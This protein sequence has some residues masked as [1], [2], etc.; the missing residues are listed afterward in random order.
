MNTRSER[1][2][3]LFD[4]LVDLDAAQRANRL[5]AIAADDVALADELTRMLA[6]DDRGGVLDGGVAAL[7]VTVA[8]ELERGPR[9]RNEAAGRRVGPF[10]LVRLLGR[11]GMGEVWLAS[12]EEGGFRQEVALKRLRHGVR[13]EDL[14][15][16]FVQERR[17]LAGLSHPGIARF[18]DGGVD[19][20]GAPWYAMELVDGVPLT[21]HARARD[22]D[23][24]AR[25]AL[26]AAVAE[27]VAYAQNRL[28]VHRDLK[29]SNILVDA[30]GRVRLLDFGIAKLLDEVPD[31]RATAS[32]VRAMSPAYAAPEQILG[33]PI[34]AATDVYALGVVLYELLTGGLPHARGDASLETLAEQ[35]RGE[36][37]E[38]PSRRL[39]RADAS[40]V[41]ALGGDAATALRF[42]RAAAGELDTIV[43][44]ALRREQERRYANAAAL[45]DDLRR[46]L[47]GRP[48]A[49]QP[50]TATYRLR[51]FVARHR[52]AVGSASAV[53]LALVAGTGIALWQAGV[54][55]D[56]ARRAG[57]E[58][59]RAEREAEKSDRV[60]EFM[61]S[62]LKAS[63][64]MARGTTEVPTVGEVVARAAR[65]VERDL[66]DAPMAQAAVLAEL[67]SIAFNGE[68][69][70]IGTAYA[71]RAAALLEGRPGI[72]PPL[73]ASVARVRGEA[74]LRGGDPVGAEAVF[75][76][77]SRLL[78][79]EL[80][81]P[82]PR[83]TARIAAGQ[84]ANG[85]GVALYVQ[86]RHADA[87]AALSRAA[88]LHAEVYGDDSPQVGVQHANLAM[89]H[90]SIGR[91]QEAL[92]SIERALAVHLLHLAPDDPRLAVLRGTEARILDDLGRSDEALRAAGEALGIAE[93]AHGPDAAELTD[94]LETLA[95]VH[96]MRGGLAEAEP[97]LA[98][99][100]AI[101][102]ASGDARRRF[103]LTRARG[104]LEMYR[105]APAAAIPWYA[106]ALEA[107]Q[108]HAAGEGAVPLMTRSMLAWARGLA[109][110]HDAALAELED[111][112]VALAALPQPDPTDELVRRY[113]AGEVALR[114]GRR[115]T[116]V[117]HLREAL[118]LA[119]ANPPYATSTFAHQ[120]RIALGLALWADVGK[121]DEARALLESGIAGLEGKSMD[122]HPLVGAGRQ[123]LAS[124][125]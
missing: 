17:I 89:L 13:S 110:E 52:F 70:A 48:V 24:R 123:A 81:L 76:E 14:L 35:V 71:E 103:T 61:A 28:V 49:A 15:R 94:V 10:A 121:R 63:D 108:Q 12:R 96:M 125:R 55:R 67:A 83:R 113:Y 104:L 102:R 111:M 3:A 31:G 84:L 36:V 68:D 4:E 73:Q 33:E 34:S 72:D 40:S 5:A 85:L 19:D 29:P 1:V 38:P 115:P 8:E 6:A 95:D 107:A 69:V 122:F 39:R 7:A 62:L 23:V 60:A 80:S 79:P 54:A 46:W 44:A 43:L 91:P 26:I 90:W 97:L 51:K 9:G 114:A 53:L 106:E 124:A 105:S 101:A 30:Q 88:E 100:I 21:E 20:D 64:P 16:R 47:A 11:G 37:A 120:S 74:L 22:L 118:R 32:G 56:Q 45:A 77:G 2:L 99:G 86:S 65:R 109:G 25:V 75:R 87:A 59:A 82:S 116:A 41:Q 58:A 18:I 93:R 27:A 98:R 78:D 119:E 42:A 92:A 57:I 117:E 50:D 66:A 112:R